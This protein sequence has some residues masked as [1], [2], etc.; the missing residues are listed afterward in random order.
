MGNN[1]TYTTVRGREPLR[2]PQGWKDQDRAL[3]IQLER[4]LDDIYRRFDKSD[5]EALQARMTAAE[6]DI[7]ELDT[8]VGNAE[9]D[10]D[11]L[12]SRMDTAEDDIDAVE[13]R[14]DTAEG[15]ISTLQGNYT[16]VSG[17]LAALYTLTV[18]QLLA[19]G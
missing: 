2:I 5:I 17:E 10:I 4:I 3:I 12:E 7:G 13:G 14:L 11:S 16:S 8:A 18:N 9:D 6:E 15:N 19:K 1:I